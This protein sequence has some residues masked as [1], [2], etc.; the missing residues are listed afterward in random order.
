MQGLSNAGPMT[1]KPIKEQI[2]KLDEEIKEYKEE[3]ALFIIPDDYEML[4]KEQVVQEYNK[5]KT[6]DVNNQFF[7]F[8]GPE[9]ILEGKIINKYNYVTSLNKCKE[10]GFNDVTVAELDSEN[11]KGFQYCGYA[12]V[13]DSGLPLTTVYNEHNIKQKCASRIKEFNPGPGVITPEEKISDFKAPILCK[14]NM[15]T[16]GKMLAQCATEGLSNEECNMTNLENAKKIRAR[17]AKCINYGL[18]DAECNDLAIQAKEDLKPECD[19]FNI[20]MKQCTVPN[21]IKARNDAQLAKCE[22]LGVQE[23]CSAGAIKARE[24]YIQEN[25]EMFDK[26]KKYGMS[27][28]DCNREKVEMEELKRNKTNENSILTQNQNNPLSALLANSNVNS[29]DDSEGPK[30]RGF[31]FKNIILW[32]LFIYFI[33][34]FVIKRQK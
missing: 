19:K 25:K 16:Y 21:L 17:K 31:S 12:Y 11:K 6:K 30:I 22:E 7:L 1:T 18:G 10:F 27:F 4:K 33:Y 28:K 14:G 26:C 2:A 24:F 3:L 34:K 23:E 8:S 29:E 5:Q 15:A 13:S 20:N 9:T 32:G